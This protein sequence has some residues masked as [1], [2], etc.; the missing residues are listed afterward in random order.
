MGVF[1]W[2]SLAYDSSLRWQRSTR[3]FAERGMAV[4]DRL[5][6]LSVDGKDPRPVEIQRFFHN[7]GGMETLSSLVARTEPE[8]AWQNPF[9]QYYMDDEMIAVADCLMSL[10]KAIRQGSEPEYGPLQARRDQ[11]LALAMQDSAA[12]GGAPVQLPVDIP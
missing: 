4:G 5:T 11:E 8:I 12:S 2:S 1:D 6:L 3:F 10:V 9:R 7:V